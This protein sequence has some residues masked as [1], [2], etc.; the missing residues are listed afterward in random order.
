[1]A[2]PH[3]ISQDFGDG[4]EAMGAIDGETYDYR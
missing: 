3:T 2:A 1:M 4:G